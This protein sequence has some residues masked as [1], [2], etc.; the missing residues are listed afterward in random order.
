MGGL[1]AALTD[2]GVGGRADPP[3]LAFGDGAGDPVDDG[4]AVVVV[5]E[6]A[7]FLRNE[8]AVGAEN[9]A[10]RIALDSVY[11][12]VIVLPEVSHNTPMQSIGNVWPRAKAAGVG[13]FDGSGWFPGPDLEARKKSVKKKKKG[14]DELSMLIYHCFSEVWVRRVIRHS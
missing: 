10:E 6:V 3:Q 4:R 2:G 12:T 8:G 13:F 5:V 11:F 7:Q 1:Q 14:V 9:P